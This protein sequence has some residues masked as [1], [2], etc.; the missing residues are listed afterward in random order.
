M[1]DRDEQRHLTDMLAFIAELLGEAQVSL[2]D[3]MADI[4][5]QHREMFENTPSHFRDMTEIIDSLPAY[6]AEAEAVRKA[7]S[8][9]KKKHILAY[10]AENPYFG[11]IRIRE[12]GH[13]TEDIYIGISTLWSR[14]DRPVIYDWRAP[15]CSLFYES[16]P[17]EVSYRAPSGDITVTMDLKRQYRIEGGAMQAMF[18]TDLKIDDPVL[19]DMLARQTGAH[20]RTIVTTIQRRQNQA[21]RVEGPRH[22]L[23]QGP[24]GSGKTSVALHRAAWLLYR[25]K[26]TLR[27]EEILILSPNA[28]FSD[29]IGEVLPSLG[30]DPVP[31]RTFMELAAPAIPGFL[32]ED[33][34]AQTE[35][36]LTHRGTPDAEKR[37][38]SIRFKGSSDF[39]KTLDAYIADMTY[40]WPR[41]RPI[42]YQGDIIMTLTEIRELYART[43][44]SVLSRLDRVRSVGLDR[45]HQYRK[46]LAERILSGLS[47][48]DGFTDR[49]EMRASARLTAA[50][51]LRDLRDRWTADTSLTGPSAYAEC[52]MRIAEDASGET[53]RICRDTVG[54]IRENRWLMAEDIGPVLYLSVRLDSDRRDP[55]I[56]HIILDEVQDYTPAQL[57]YLIQAYPQSRMTL[58][59]DMNQRAL[60]GN[61]LTGLQ[62]IGL[63][64]LVHIEL[65][66]SYRSTSEITHFC[67]SI[68]GEEAGGTIRAVDRH[69]PPVNSLPCDDES[70]MLAR[71]SE[72]LARWGD[73]YG[74]VAVI[75]RTMATARRLHARLAESHAIHLMSKDQHTF[76]HGA[77]ILPVYLA[78][79]LEFDAVTVL[80]PSEDTYGEDERLLYYTACSRALHELEVLYEGEMPLEEKGIYSY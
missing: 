35:Y 61:H 34:I 68:L 67:T 20:M 43:E 39:L 65:T 47:F 75:T 66:V 27:R 25:Y 19:Q 36:L 44:G 56:R 74:S 41:F 69:G 58:V 55:R 63:S 37:L 23:V 62:D 70:E 42:E 31:T 52:L 24:A 59:G 6:M 5:R 15:V 2:S 38:A 50:G 79:G 9:H 10:M 72:R 26:D 48:E 80:C 54:M 4:R 30:E 21:I 11:R 22:L 14:E 18:D 3:T 71:I 33:A 73:A 12:E 28:I 64:G 49:R 1:F 51:E 77:V 60:V 46:R 29:Y 8:L 76:V 40:A 17:G 57:A 53:E 45:I 32:L 78:K 16:E 7:A 13:D